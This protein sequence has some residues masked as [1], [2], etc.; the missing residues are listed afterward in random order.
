MGLYSSV[1]TGLAELQPLDARDQACAE[2]ALL[3]ARNI[4][5]RDQW[6]DK[7]RDPLAELGPKLLSALAALKMTPAARSAAMG[8]AAAPPAGSKLDELRARRQRDLG[9]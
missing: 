3:Y 6:E 7:L 2:L 5:N 4:D 9:A 8:G 1:V